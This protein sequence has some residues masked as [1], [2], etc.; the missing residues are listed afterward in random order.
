MLEYDDDL[1]PLCDGPVDM[2]KQLHAH[3]VPLL[4]RLAKRLER[5]R[6]VAFRLVVA[7]ADRAD[8]E[9]CGGY[10]P[11]GF[12]LYKK[13]VGSCGDEHGDGLDWDT[14]D[15]EPGDDP[16]ALA[17]SE[18]GTLS[19][20]EVIRIFAGRGVDPGTWLWC[21]HCERFF[22]LKDVR[23]ERGLVRCGSGV[24]CDGSARDMAVWNSWPEQNPDL[25]A[26]W[27]KT[28]A[29]LHR[30]LRASLNGP[31]PPDRGL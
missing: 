25:R 20:A 9:T 21:L 6:P 13:V 28:T 7:F 15:D 3:A 4:K 11:T 10:T 16:H 18:P 2:T 8:I 23:R 31:E 30:G 17:E 14:W 5:G 29:E 22:Q 12:D 1:C 27:P 19:T 24:P 26:W